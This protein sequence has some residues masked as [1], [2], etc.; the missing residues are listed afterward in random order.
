MNTSDRQPPE[1]APRR[2]WLAP[3]NPPLTDW[4]GR[5]VWLLGASTGIGRAVAEALHARGAQVFVSA[6][7]EAA[8]AAFAATHHGVQAMPLDTTDATAVARVASEL[9]EG[10]GIDCAVYCAGYYRAQRATDFDLQ[11]MLQHERVN[12]TGALHMLAAVLPAML[13]RGGGHI[14]LVSSVA[15]FRGMPNSLAYGPTKAALINLAETLYIDLSD[16][17]IGVSLI[18][19][20]FVETPLTAQNTFEMPALIT[21]EQAAHAIL[22]GWRRGHFEIH[23]PLRFTLG[24]KLLALLPFRL[25]QAAVRRITGL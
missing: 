5:R 23:F 21:P 4:S 18:N 15:G 12:Y 11:E 17:G 14:S 16:R 20:G 25:Y 6:R 7:G 10:G 2:R 9:I 24:V 3:L 13:A 19:P 1:R 8:L 22:A